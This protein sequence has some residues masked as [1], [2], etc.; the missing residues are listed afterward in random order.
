MCSYFYTYCVGSI[1]VNK[2]LP[3]DKV[4]DPTQSL[5]GATDQLFSIL[6]LSS[7]YLEFSYLFYT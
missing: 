7:I 6:H 5:Y 4:L 2:G 3:I 1:N